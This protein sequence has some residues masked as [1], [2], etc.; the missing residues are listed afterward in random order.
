MSVRMRN[1]RMIVGLGIGLGILG[2]VVLPPMYARL[3]TLQLAH[4]LDLRFG[5]TGWVV[6][7][8]TADA[9]S[10][11]EI[12]LFRTLYVRLLF[13]HF[14]EFT[15]WKGLRFTE[16][17]TT[18][19]RPWHYAVCTVSEGREVTYF[20]SI[21]QHRWVVAWDNN[22]RDFPADERQR[23]AAM[24]QRVARKNGLNWATGRAYAL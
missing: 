2:L 1:S 20:W 17:T 5:R 3:V 23:Y 7:W 14:Q 21:R 11:E 8:R 13:P 15:P 24:L 18:P 6:V 19:N 12:A 4:S 16:K 9:Q 22:L 10:G